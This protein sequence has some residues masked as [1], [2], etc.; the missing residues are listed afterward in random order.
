MPLEGEE[1]WG[2]EVKLVY[3]EINLLH[4]N[5]YVNYKKTWIS[6]KTKSILKCQ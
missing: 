1:G 4:R 6:N 5:S 3:A 2:R